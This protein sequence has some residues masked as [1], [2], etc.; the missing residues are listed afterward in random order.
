MERDQ[1]DESFSSVP[2]LTDDEWL[3]RLHFST[4]HI[5]DGDVI[6]AAISL[7]DLSTRGFSVDREAIVNTDTLVARACIQSNNKPEQRVQPFLS[8]CN[9]GAVRSIT[10]EDKQAFKV[11]ESPQ[12]DNRAHAHI[13][14][15]QPLGKG[16]LRKLRSLLL[17]HL[18]ELVPLDQ[19]VAERKS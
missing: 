4:E 6:P 14:S 10:Y 1:Q 3:L 18:Q 19:Y 2:P 16:S 15:A 7:E 13:L 17:V 8:R 12:P 11:E 9:C 5:Q